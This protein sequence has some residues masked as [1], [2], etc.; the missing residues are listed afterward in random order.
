MGWMERHGS[1][2]SLFCVHSVGFCVKKKQKNCDSP[3]CVLSPLSIGPFG[4]GVA[5]KNSKRQNQGFRETPADL[6]QVHALMC[7]GTGRR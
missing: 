6:M 5:K 3:G 2:G 1:S 7:L 4:L